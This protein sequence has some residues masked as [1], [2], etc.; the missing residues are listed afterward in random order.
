MLQEILGVCSFGVI[1][2]RISDPRSFES[3]CIKGVDESVARVDSFLPLVHHDL[4]DH[5]SLILIEITPKE[6]TLW[7]KILKKYQEM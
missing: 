1:C 6:C 3:W 7:L 2:I 5:G 4:S